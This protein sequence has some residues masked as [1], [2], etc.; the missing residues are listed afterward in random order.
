MNVRTIH[1]SQFQTIPSILGIIL[2]TQ[3]NYEK[4]ITHQ[5]FE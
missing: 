1:S 5:C 3:Q 2:K 4:N